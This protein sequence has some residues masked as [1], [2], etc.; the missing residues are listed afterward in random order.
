ME[1]GFEDTFRHGW[2]RDLMK[3]VWLT[4]EDEFS[5]LLT[6][7]HADDVLIAVMLGIR[8]N[9]IM[10]AWI[11]AYNPAF[12]KYSPGLLLHLELAKCAEENDFNRIELGRGENRMKTSLMNGSHKMALG[13]ADRRLIF[14]ALNTAWFGIRGVIHSPYFKG[15]PLQSAR[16]LKNLIVHNST[17]VS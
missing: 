8:G 5:G 14:S 4:R 6:T 11:P 9:G 7:L 10:N 12:A 1:Q 3:E 17:K 13:A 15:W 2:V 16:K